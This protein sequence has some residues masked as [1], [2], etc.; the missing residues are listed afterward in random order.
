MKPRRAA[1]WRRDAT[2]PLWMTDCRSYANPR[3]RGQILR[4]MEKTSRRDRRVTN[5]EESTDREKL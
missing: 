4:E 1:V 2:L 5:P 3:G